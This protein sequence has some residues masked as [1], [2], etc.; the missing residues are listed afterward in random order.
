[1]TR[2]SLGTHRVARAIVTQSQDFTISVPT[3]FVIERRLLDITAPVAERGLSR[4]DAVL[5]DDT[6]PLLTFRA[7]AQAQLIIVS[8][9]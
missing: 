5:I 7:T 3:L 9:G 4:C 1:M 8:F 2:R 6:T